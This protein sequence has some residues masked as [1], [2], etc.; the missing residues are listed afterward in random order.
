M[1]DEEVVNKNT[2]Y[3]SERLLIFN[4]LLMFALPAVF[5]GGTSDFVTGIFIAL[6]ILAPINVFVYSRSWLDASPHT[7]LRFLLALSPYLAAFA[8]TLAGLSHPALEQIQIGSREYL[9]LVKDG[10]SMLTSAASGFLQAVT[11]DLIT[12]GCAACGLSIYFITES[13]Y[14]IRRIIFYCAVI[15]ACIA[16]L[17]MAYEEILSFMGN[18][19]MPSFGD[20]GFFTYP[21]ASWWAS[22]A[23]LWMGGAL[24]VAVYSAQRFRLSMFFYSL[25]FLSLLAA[26]I[27]F[28][29]ILYC[30]AP[31]ERALAMLLAAFAFLVLAVDTFPSNRNLSRHW[32]SKYSRRRNS[33]FISTAVIPCAAYSLAAL[34]S[35]ASCVLT[36]VDFSNDESQ[37]LVADSDR[38]GCATLAE[39]RA[40]L[41][42]SMEIIEI[43]PVFGWGT[44]SF[45]NVFAFYQG[46]DLGDCAWDSPLSEPVKK[47][48][49]NG[50]AGIAL[51]VS[52]PLVFFLIWIFRFDFSASGMVLF[53]TLACFSV[54]AVI[55]CPL[56][57]MA[58]HISF[59]VLLMSMF[60]WDCAK[61]R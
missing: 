24:T 16:A 43:K 61:I 57:C 32:T 26:F 13:R 40:L 56:Q 39:R 41:A 2:R 17:G 55:G 36:F 10:G 60:K 44:G 9:N 59:W 35:A 21:Y 18:E 5:F 58:V 1:L 20:G 45:S 3:G 42:D 14:I 27:L 8:I 52:T 33:N 4:V 29:S 53:F 46:S 15:A 6:G 11:P 49:E 38:G 22:L 28:V 54:L 47:I 31:I 51:S 48:I 34:V 19:N 7:W 37:M 23:L 30:G 12:I 25:R 50:F